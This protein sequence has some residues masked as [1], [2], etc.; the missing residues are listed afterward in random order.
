MS[1]IKGVFFDLG[2]TLRVCE[3]DEAHQTEARK[4]MAELA[5]FDD[6]QAFIDMIDQRY[7]TAYRK[8]ALEENKESGDY[9]LWAKWLLPELSEEKLQ[10]ICHETGFLIYFCACLWGTC[11]KIW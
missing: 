3:P 10:S 11:I 6:V 7:E 1:E 2:G 9:E 5:G 8:W 4:R